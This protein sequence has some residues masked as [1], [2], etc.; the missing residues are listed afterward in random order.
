MRYTR[1][2]LRDMA[3]IVMT[4]QANG[5]KRALQLTLTISLRANIDPQTVWAQIQELAK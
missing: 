5:G 4:D 2:Q 1:E 3:R